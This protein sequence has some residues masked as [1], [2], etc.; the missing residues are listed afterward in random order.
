MPAL[1]RALGQALPAA[2]GVAVERLL[3]LA[4]ILPMGSA[5]PWAKVVLEDPESEGQ[6]T[7]ALRLLHDPR[8]APLIRS[9]LQHPDWQVRVRAIAALEPVASTEDVP[10]LLRALEDPEWWVRRRAARTL[11]RLPFLDDAGIAKLR[12]KV[13]DRFG[14]DALAQA[15]DEDKVA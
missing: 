10:Y 12:A 14:Q 3:L 5:S 7:A 11:V 4:A 6:I 1:E 8:D 2:K 13:Q 15:L 9:F